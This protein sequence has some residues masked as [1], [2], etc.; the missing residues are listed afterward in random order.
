MPINF[1]LWSVK[2]LTVKHVLLC[3][4]NN[5]IIDEAY[6]GF[7][8]AILK[9]ISEYTNNAV[10]K[11]NIIRSIQ[12]NNL[13]STPISENSPLYLMVSSQ[14]VPTSLYDTLDTYT[15]STKVTMKIISI[16]NFIF[17]ALFKKIWRL[18]NDALTHVNK[19]YNIKKWQKFP[20]NNRKH[21]T[22]RYT[23]DDSPSSDSFDHN[24]LPYYDNN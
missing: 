2:T 5:T 19:S 15:R 23:K 20:N 16:M 24:N 1:F 12:R 11:N 13:F 14:L 21:A 18:H 3:T 17:E 7:V 4:A 22:W 6:D 9:L 10:G 8:N